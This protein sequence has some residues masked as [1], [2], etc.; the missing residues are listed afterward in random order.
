MKASLST[1]S[2]RKKIWKLYKYIICY[3]WIFGQ[4]NDKIQVLLNNEYNLIK[5]IENRKKLIKDNEL[6]DISLQ[7]II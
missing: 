5:N 3:Y 2:V 7:Q 6:K 4:N 1:S